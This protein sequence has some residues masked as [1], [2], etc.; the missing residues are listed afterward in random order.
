MKI[1]QLTPFFLSALGPYIYD[2][3]TKGG[4]WSLEICHVFAN[5]IVFKQYIY[6]SF[7]RMV[8]VGCQKMIIFC[9]RRKWMTPFRTL[10]A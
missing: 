9:A 6:C 2:V 7:L 8:G 4:C 3:H 1:R 10:T 5:S